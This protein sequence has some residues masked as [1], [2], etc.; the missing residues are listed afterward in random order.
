MFKTKI[1]KRKGVQQSLW[2]IVATVIFLVIVL[3]AIIWFSGSTRDLGFIENETQN[4]SIEFL[5]CDI[6]CSV[7]CHG[8][9]HLDCSN[10]GGLDKEVD[11]CHCQD[12][13]P[14]EHGC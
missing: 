1:A 4:R 10:T 6:V 8:V 9:K 7:C 11:E 3:V 14:L 12:S 5:R 13:K 2:I